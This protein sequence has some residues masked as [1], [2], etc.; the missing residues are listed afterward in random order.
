MV[1]GAVLAGTGVGGPSVAAQQGESADPATCRVT[2]LSQGFDLYRSVRLV[3]AAELAG[4]VDPAPRLLRRTFRERVE[5]SCAELLKLPWIGSVTEESRSGGPHVRVL[6]GAARSSFSSAFPMDRNNGALWEGRGANLSLQGGAVLE[7]GP[8]TAM[9]APL[10]AFSQNRELEFVARGGA[11]R[12]EFAYRPGIDWPVRFGDGAFWQVDPGPSAIRVDGAGMSVGFSNE[13]LWWGPALENPILFSNTAPGF[14]HVFI[15]TD[16]PLDLGGVARLELELI[17]G[18]LQESDYFDDDPSNDTRLVVATGVGLQL[19]GLSNLAIG[20]GRVYTSTLPEEPFDFVEVYLTRP[21]RDIRRNPKR[22][23]PGANDQLFAAWLRWPL[24][25]TGFEVYAEWA[26]EDQFK[27]LQDLAKEPDHS[28]GYV[29]GLQKALSMMSRSL[30]VYVEVAHLERASTALSGRTNPPFYRNTSVPQGHTQRGQ[31]LGAGIGPGSN[32]QILGAEL[33]SGDR[34]LE[35]FLR[36]VQTDL[37][38]YDELSEAARS[39]FE[40]DHMTTLGVRGWLRRGDLTLEGRV[41]LTRRTNRDLLPLSPD[42]NGQEL[43][44]TNLELELG[45]HHRLRF[46]A[47]EP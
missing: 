33:L 41:A 10:V 28:Q 16:G 14:P 34:S 45:V 26:R 3:R 39:G 29:A 7:W 12:S 46:L 20:A 5:G 13:G 2:D 8:L 19:P 23:L 24:T 25:V 40:P 22:G 6:G 4:A 36:R 35:I 21:Y 30:R 37:D 17:W 32:A 47:R 27:D 38:R 31:I 18:H 43:K 11:G 1:V 15:G 9:L 42:R 44:E